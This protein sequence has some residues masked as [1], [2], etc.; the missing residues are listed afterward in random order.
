MPKYKMKKKKLEKELLPI[1]MKEFKKWLIENYGKKCKDYSDC[2]V[3]CNAWKV[4]T[5]LKKLLEY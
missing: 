4:Y 2:C 1:N 5:M 3:I